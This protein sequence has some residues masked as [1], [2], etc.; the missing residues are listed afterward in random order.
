LI[1]IGNFLNATPFNS[2]SSNVPIVTKITPQSHGYV[3]SYAVNTFK[4]KKAPGAIFYEI[5]LYGKLGCATTGCPWRLIGKAYFPSS[6]DYAILR[7]GVLKSGIIYAWNVR[8]FTI[9]RSGRIS[10]GRYGK[11]YSFKAVGSSNNPPVTTPPVSSG[12]TSSSNSNSRNS[13][14]SG[15]GTV[16][17]NGKTPLKYKDIIKKSEQQ[18]ENEVSQKYGIKFLIWSQDPAKWT[19]DEKAWA[20]EDWEHMYL[21]Y[22]NHTKAVYRERMYRSPYVLGYVMIPIPRVHMLNSACRSKQQFQNTLAHEMAH[23]FQCDARKI[24]TEWSQT[25]HGISQPYFTSAGRRRVTGAPT[26]YGNTNTFEDMAESVRCYIFRPQYLKTQFP[27][28]YNF[29]KTK[30][31]GGK[32]YT[33]REMF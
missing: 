21:G 5:V 14:G 27:K 19:K 4:W 1:T 3:K 15:S 9:S 18:I 26:A 31:M 16:A 20:Y 13:G 33:G 7:Q 11:W 29:I 17:N 23:C 6:R 28:R 10:G 12:S 30:M 22:V 2:V 32:E 24:F 25:F 8:A